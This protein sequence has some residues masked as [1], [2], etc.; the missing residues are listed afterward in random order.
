MTCLG[1]KG[2]QENSLL[3]K[4][5]LEVSV[6]ECRSASVTQTEGLEIKVSS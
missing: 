1:V 3:G 4:G 6:F 5:K 2:V